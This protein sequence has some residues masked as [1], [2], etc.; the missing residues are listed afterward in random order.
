M[1]DELVQLASIYGSPGFLLLASTETGDRVGCVGLRSLGTIDGM[2][3]GEMRRLF[4]RDEFRGVGAGR[5]LVDM[6]RSEAYGNRFGRIVL[7]TLPEM[8]SA[9]TLYTSIGF[10]SSRPHVDEPAEGTLYFVLD[11]PGK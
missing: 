5:A 10:E 7:N 3:V 4:V 11:L 8:T 6:M 1:E 9:Q 2:L